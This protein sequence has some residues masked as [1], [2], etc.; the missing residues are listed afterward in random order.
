MQLGSFQTNTVK[1]VQLA[2]TAIGGAARPVLVIM[3]TPMLPNMR[4]MN[5]GCATGA[6]HGA[7]RSGSAG[8]SEL[9]QELNLAR[10]LD[11]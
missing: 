3:D 7:S 11:C 8:S 9:L 4:V 5:F 6:T 10:R 2:A 1:P